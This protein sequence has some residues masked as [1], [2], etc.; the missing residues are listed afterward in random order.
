MNNVWYTQYPIAHRGWHWLEG[1]DE[2]SWEAIELALKKGYPIEFDVH[3]S[4][5]GVA[6]IHHDETLERM[7][8]HKKNI[9]ELSSQALREIKTLNS[10]HGIP[11]LKEVLA[12]VRGQVPLVIEVKKTRGDN[13]LEEAVHECVKNYKGDFSIQS[14]HP[15]TLRFYRNE[16]VTFPLGLLSADFKEDNLNYFTKLALKSLCLTPFLKPDYIGYHYLSLSKRAPQ[17]MREHYQIPLLGWTVRDQHAKTVCDKYADNI[18]F[19]NIEADNGFD[20]QK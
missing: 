20:E 10:N 18:I 6:V 8:G 12:R 9:G 14:F 3:L 1:V 16:K 15:S 7:T 2:N 13:A 4:K 5:D 19:E 17:H 11:V